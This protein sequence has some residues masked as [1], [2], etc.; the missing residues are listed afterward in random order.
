MLTAAAQR[1]RPE[2]RSARPGLATIRGV[3]ATE[4]RHRQHQL[5]LAT[6]VLLVLGA[7]AVVLD[8]AV[9]AAALLLVAIV[10]AV[11]WFRTPEVEYPDPVL[12]AA[13]V[14]ELRRRR[15]GGGEVG[16]VRALREQF[17]ALGL[18]QAVRIVRAL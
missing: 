16:A 15:D 9:F 18:A 10:V 4:N 14:A 5:L 6:T 13:F 17:P 1:G 8:L 11:I 7:A 3:D 12:S 2:L